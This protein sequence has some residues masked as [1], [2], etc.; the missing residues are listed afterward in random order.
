V[1]LTEKG[2]VVSAVAVTPILVAPVYVRWLAL[3]KKQKG[4]EGGGRGCPRRK[5]GGGGKERW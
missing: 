5:M 1:E 4:K 3:D 2:V